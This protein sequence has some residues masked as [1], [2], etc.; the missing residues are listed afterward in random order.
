M[1]SSVDVPL[2]PHSLQTQMSASELGLVFGTTRSTGWCQ[3][4]LDFGQRESP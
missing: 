2:R 3:P 4:V 1:G